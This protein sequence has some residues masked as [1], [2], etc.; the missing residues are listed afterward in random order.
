MPS[1]RLGLRIVATP[2]LLL[3]LAF[4]VV[5]WMTVSVAKGSLFDPSFYLTALRQSHAYDRIYTDVLKDPGSQE[6]VN[7]LLG[8]T[9][10]LS[11]EDTDRLLRQILPPEYL[12]RESERNIRAVVAYLRK[13]TNDLVLGVELRPILENVRPVA[14]EYAAKRLQSVERVPVDSYGAYST[15]L[16]EIVDGLKRGQIPESVPT[17]QFSEE[18]KAAT[19]AAIVGDG[20]ASDA[21]KNAVAQ[22]LAGTDTAAALTAALDPLLRQRTDESLVALR[23]KLAPGDVLDLLGQAASDQNTTKAEMLSGL[24]PVRDVVWTVNTWGLVLAPGIVLVATTLLGVVYLPSRTRALA[25]AG[26]ALLLVGIPAG[27]GLWMV[28]DAAPGR[29]HDAIVDMQSESPSAERLLAADVASSMVEDGTS[30]AWTPIVA[31]IIVGGVLVG[32]SIASKF[33]IRRADGE[34]ISAE[35]PAQVPEPPGSVG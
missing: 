16:G 34:L 3:L 8:G 1:A 26:A 32:A 24:Q 7:D 18:E 15:R 5:A 13:D 12:Q 2:L 11:P 14:V 6:K 28:H 21:E 27:I 22:A 9:Q 31:F 10:A 23:Q 29:L 33:A 30:S 4:T 35:E 17:Y 20:P 19:L 25:V